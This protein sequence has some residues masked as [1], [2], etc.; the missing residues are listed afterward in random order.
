VACHRIGGGTVQGAQ[1]A[2]DFGRQLFGVDF[3]RD[4]GPIGGWSIATG[5]IGLRLGWARA[6]RA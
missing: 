5:A 6:A 3:R 2:P 1:F 4:R